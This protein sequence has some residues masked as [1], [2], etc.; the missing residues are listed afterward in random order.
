MIGLGIITCK[1]PEFFEQ[2]YDSIP[3]DNIDELV[4]IDASPA[5][6]QYAEDK[7]GKDVSKVY[8][9]AGGMVVGKAKNKAL[10]HL[11]HQGAKHMF[12][13]EDDV[14]IKNPDIFEKYITTASKTGMYGTLAH[15]AHGNGNRDSEG[16]LDIKNTVDYGDGVLLDF[17]QNS[18]HPFC[19][20]YRG[21]YKN[22][23][24]FDENYVNAIEHLDHY[25]AQEIKK[26]SSYYWWFPTPAGSEDDIVDLDENHSASVI[27]RD[28]KWSQHVVEGMK[29]FRGKYKFDP[30]TMPE[31][32]EI[33]MLERLDHLVKKQA[34]KYF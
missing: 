10:A 22:I 27:R 15:N 20:M 1:R 7:V 30:F 11:Y 26:L 4:V 18:V 28:D 3:R 33:Q 14:L 19:Y 17:F 29:R 8:S 24:G 31:A 2:V 32:G 16:A 12:L 13:I 21:L 34:G 6:D 25:K 9:A 5:A 23:G